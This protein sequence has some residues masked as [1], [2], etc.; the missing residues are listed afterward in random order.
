LF[1]A[2][3]THVEE[4]EVNETVEET[5]RCFLPSQRVQPTQPTQPKTFQ[6]AFDILYD[7]VDRLGTTEMY[8]TQRLAELVKEAKEKWCEINNLIDGNETQNEIVRSLDTPLEQETQND[9]VRSEEP[10]TTPETTPDPS[11]APPA[12]PIQIS[13]TP[14]K[15]HIRKLTTIKPTEVVPE[16][17]R[18]RTGTLDTIMATSSTSST[19]SPDS[20]TESTRSY[21]SCTPYK[22]DLNNR[23]IRRI[24]NALTMI[25]E[26]HMPYKQA[27]YN[28]RE[29]LEDVKP[30]RNLCG[31]GYDVLQAYIEDE[32]TLKELDSFMS[33][34]DENVY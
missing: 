5:E 11:L 30:Y 17:S 22:W 14:V 1:G 29:L 28:Y 23:H 9:I 7:I 15:K 27:K 3:P 10:A 25:L 33:L 2:T 21:V 26:E 4:P 34:A 20:D 8:Q 31:K 12:E 16:M 24:Y 32:F 19:N 6:K 13:P 18:P